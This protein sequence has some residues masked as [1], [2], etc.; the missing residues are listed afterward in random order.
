[1]IKWLSERQVL[2]FSGLLVIAYL[3]FGYAVFLDGQYMRPIITF[4]KPTALSNTIIREPACSYTHLTTEKEYHPGDVVSAYVNVE[5]F[6]DIEAILQWNL[7]DARFYRY[8]PRRGV[9]AK[10]IFNRVVEIEILPSHI[11]PG[12][13]FFEGSIKYETNPLQDI[14]ISIR[15]NKF[16]VVKP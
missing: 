15:T 1:M 13:Y 3:I 2:I 12:T 4:Y 9:L 10:G 7:M 8:V 11:P 14:Y 6:R 5:K 16:E